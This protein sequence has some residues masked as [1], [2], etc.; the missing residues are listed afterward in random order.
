MRVLY[1]GKYKSI[2]PNDEKNMSRNITKKNI[3]GQMPRQ[4][5]LFMKQSTI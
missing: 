2:L 3:K 4:K 5:T 1:S